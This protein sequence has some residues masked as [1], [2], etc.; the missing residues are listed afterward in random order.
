MSDKHVAEPVPPQGI[1]LPPIALGP[2]MAERRIV[3]HEANGREREVLARLGMP[4]PVPSGLIP[5]SWYRCPTQIVGL[6]I[7]EK[8][9]APAGADV[10]EALYNALDVIGQQLD[11]RAE[12]LE[13]TNPSKGLDTRSLSWIWKYPPTE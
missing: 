10:F 4:I 11:Y 12:Q 13:L 5:F 8:I 3:L 2:V 6:G 9:I 1:Q 7:D